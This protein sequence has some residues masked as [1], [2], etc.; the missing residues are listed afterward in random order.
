MNRDEWINYGVQHGW[1]SF[2]VCATH[3]SLPTTPEELEMW[4][5]GADLCMFGMRLWEEGQFELY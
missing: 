5:E 4:D 3:G 1:C 2:P